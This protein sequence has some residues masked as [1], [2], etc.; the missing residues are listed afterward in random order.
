M[1]KPFKSLDSLL[2]LMRKRNITI[3][4]G[5]EGSR[6]KRIL[7]RDNYYSIINGYKD[8]F[9][10]NNA[11]VN[12]GDDYYIT[13]TTFFQIYGLY[14]FDR[15]LR[16]ILLKALL[17]AEQNICTK[18]SYRFSEV[19]TSE[20]SHLNVNNFSKTNLPKATELVS[21][22]SNATQRNARHTMFSHYLTTHQDLPLWVLVTKLTFGEI[23]NFYKLITPNIQEKI[24]ED[25]H[26][27]YMTEYR[28]SIMHPTSTLIPI[29]SEI[30]DVL[31]GYRNVCAHGDRLYNH[32]IIGPKKTIKKLTYYFVP[33]PKGS[34]SSVYGVLISL[35]LLLPR[36]AYKSI[37]DE[38]IS[39]LLLLK[40]SLPIIQFNQVLAKMELTLQWN[41][42]LEALK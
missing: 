16:I 2:R 38:I 31:V 35:R 9:L 36:I 27:E 6:V 30:L 20:F 41:Q 19:H 18:V 4:K 15:N 1:S 14:C 5:T 23:T 28:I 24:L 13:G 42:T 21:K 34:E 40:E 33:N 32:R 3:E 29:F 11:T 12:S 26:K 37:I 25:I 8:I 22:L 17:Q 10:D 39:E 7:A